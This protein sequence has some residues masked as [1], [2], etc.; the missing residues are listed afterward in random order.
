MH[1]VLNN[2]L[3]GLRSDLGR[4][5]DDLRASVLP[6]PDPEPTASDRASFAAFRAWQIRVDG[7]APPEAELRQVFI[8]RPNGGVGRYRFKESV[9]DAVEAGVRR[10]TDLGTVPALA[11]YAIPSAA[12]EARDAEAQA[13]A[14]ARGASHARVIRLTHANHLVFLSNESDVLVEVNAFLDQLTK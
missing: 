6:T 10:Y 5:Q 14:F 2:D 9:A 7:V 11:I 3:P 13:Q 4:L 1:A 12:T 8:A